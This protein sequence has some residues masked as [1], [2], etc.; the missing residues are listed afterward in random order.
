M[1][2]ISVRAV[3]S[4]LLLLCFLFLAVTGAAM[5]FNKTGMVFGIPR[6]AMRGAHFWV[7][8][9]I[10]V[11][12]AAHLAF[13]RRVYSAELRALVKQEGNRRRREK[14]E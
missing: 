6:Y 12:A 8:V 14:G 4:T 13:N 9:A 10:L 2:K 11:L 7:A 5:Y 1:N 3:I